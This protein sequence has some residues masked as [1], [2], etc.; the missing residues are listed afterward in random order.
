MQRQQR[1]L[2]D[3]A[4]NKRILI[5]HLEGRSFL[6]RLFPGEA[7]FVLIRVDDADALIRFCAER[8]VIIRGFPSDPLLQDCVR[9]SVGSDDEIA[10]LA[11]I[12]DEWEN[13]K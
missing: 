1:L 10:L 8:N 7:N 4:R 12:L 13:R 5:G 6:R 9:I 3:V 2:S 11:E